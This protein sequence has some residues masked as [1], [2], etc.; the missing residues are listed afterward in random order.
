MLESS[1]ILPSVVSYLSDALPFYT[2]NLSS[3]ISTQRV[4]SIYHPMH[5]VS[6][7]HCSPL[8]VFQL[9]VPITCAFDAFAPAIDGT[10][11]MILTRHVIQCPIDNPC[12]EC[13]GQIS[14][15]V[16]F[17]IVVALQR[18]RERA[19][20]G[21]HDAKHDSCSIQRVHHVRWPFSPVLTLYKGAD[22]SG[23]PTDAPVLAVP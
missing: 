8:S 2:S 20:H 18:Q 16:H 14:W 5:S 21:T 17:T 6:G 1:S 10:T 12:P 3:H 4:I 13:L 9:T 11:R 19:H 15:L 7:R 22:G 23:R